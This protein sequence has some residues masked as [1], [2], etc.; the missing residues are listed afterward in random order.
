MNVETKQNKKK[1]NRRQNF[2]KVSA[3]YKSKF[4]E[5]NAGSPPMVLYM[6]VRLG[7]TKGRHYSVGECIFIYI[8]IYIYYDAQKVY[9]S[10]RLNIYIYI[11]LEVVTH[12]LQALLYIYICVCLCLHLCLYIYI[13]YIDCINFKSYYF[14]TTLFLF[15]SLLY[16]FYECVIY[17]L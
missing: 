7:R 16:H 1:K 10:R 13:L 15:S 11:V 2:Y 5:E 6:C 14:T 9:I 4:P 3:L 17:S 12:A 8:N